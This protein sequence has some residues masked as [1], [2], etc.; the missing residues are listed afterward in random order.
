MATLVLLMTMAA[1]AGFGL[2]SAGFVVVF[3]QN[4]PFTGALVALSFLLS[5]IFCR[6]RTRWN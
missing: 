6:S 3:K 5:G 2:M 4:E 1:L